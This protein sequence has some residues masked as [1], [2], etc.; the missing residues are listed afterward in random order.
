MSNDICFVDQYPE[1]ANVT[2]EE[3]TIEFNS[4]AANWYEETFA[5]TDLTDER[6]FTL[7]QYPVSD[8]SISVFLNSGA[9]RQG[10]DYTVAGNIISFVS[11]LTAADVIM[12]RYFAYE[13]ATDLGNV[14]IGAVLWQA[15][16]VAPEGY[17]LAD[18]STDY[19]IATYPALYTYCVDNSINQ[20]GST[21]DDFQIKDLGMTVGA[22]TLYAIIKA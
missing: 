9:Q 7:A 13:A 18:G 16:G 17:C 2:V 6:S 14:P 8:G 12:V 20:A 21:A 5:Y 4:A 1:A 3:T 19:T 15:S 22:V 11:S 10:T